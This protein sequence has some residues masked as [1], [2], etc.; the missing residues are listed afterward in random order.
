MIYFLMEKKKGLFV[1]GVIEK[2]LFMSQV[3]NRMGGPSPLFM[4]V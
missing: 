3:K 1:S 2:N 4:N